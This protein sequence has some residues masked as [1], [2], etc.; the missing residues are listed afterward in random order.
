MPAA[1]AAPR[2]GGDDRECGAPLAGVQIQ[3]SKVSTVSMSVSLAG[4]TVWTNS[5]TI[6]GGRPRLLWLTPS[7][8]GIYTVQLRAKDLAG[9]E[10]S[11][12]GT[13]VLSPRT[14]S[15]PMPPLPVMPQIVP[16]ATHG[17]FGA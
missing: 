1:G 9:N 5:A 11:T 3:L 8:S 10:A 17:C 12:S 6:E 13:I 4:K 16:H 2:V 7:K 15:V 14:P